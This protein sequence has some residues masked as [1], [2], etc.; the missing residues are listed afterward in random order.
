[1]QVYVKILNATPVCQLAQI[2]RRDKGFQGVIAMTK[3]IFAQRLLA[4]AAVSGLLAGPAFAQMGPPL[5]AGPFVGANLGGVLSSLDVNDPGTTFTAGGPQTSFHEHSAGF[6][7]GGQIGY[8]WQFS[9]VVLGAVADFDGSSLK[10][11]GTAIDGAFSSQ[12]DFLGTARARLGYA[13][14]TMPM[15]LYATGG[16]AFGDVKDSAPFSAVGPYPTKSG[17]R[18]GWTAGAGAEYMFARCW[19]IEAQVLYVDL[20]NTSSNVTPPGCT[21]G[22]KDRAVVTR[23]GINF[24]F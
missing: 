22:F 9:S 14:Q 11:S 20:G 21:V 19:S 7:G 16:L 3:R 24:H 23:A 5:W 13:F 2:T 12:I 6:L 10:T 1:M 15:M 18:A 8:D 17:W 4:S